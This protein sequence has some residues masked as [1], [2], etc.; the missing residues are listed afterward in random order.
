[1]LG[2]Q[3]VEH[4]ACRLLAD[5]EHGGHQLR[6]GHR[7][8]LDQPHPV[9]GAVQHSGRHLQCQ[10]GLADPAWPGD[11]DQPRPSGHQGPQ[12][13]QLAAPADKLVACDGRL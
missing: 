13:S 11:R 1:M 3:G 2:R 10:P 6:V 8:Q 9:T 5:T 7:R 12:L 4:S